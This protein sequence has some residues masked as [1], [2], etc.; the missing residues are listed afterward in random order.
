MKLNKKIIIVFVL[1]FI[2]LNVF[3]IKNFIYSA[4]AKI[5]ESKWEY[6]KVEEIS[7][8]QNSFI[9]KYNLGVSLYKEKEYNKAL[10]VFLSIFDT[11]KENF[12]LDYNIWNSYYKVWVLEKNSKKKIE[13][14]IKAISYYEKA[15]DIR[16][17][18]KAKNNI[19]FILKKIKQE[20]KKQEQKNNQE[21]KKDNKQINNSKN[22]NK[23]GQKDNS[24]KSTNSWTWTNNNSNKDKKSEN[25]SS[26]SK[27]NKSNKQGSNNKNQEN[28]NK[29]N[30]DNKW[31]KSSNNKQEW[32]KNNSQQKWWESNSKENIQ[33]NK[34]NNAERNK[35]WIN[36]NKLVNQEK[37][38]NHR[39]ESN[40]TW[41]SQHDKQLLKAYQNRVA[42]SSQNLWD[43]YWKVYKQQ[44]NPFDWFDNFFGWNDLFNN[45]EFWNNSNKKD[46]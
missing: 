14:W 42:Q 15:L 46:W 41:L 36:W 23:I 34:V 22:K 10:A 9:W 26:N 24:N 8:K 17:D 43:Y 7:K 20:R 38:E 44:S 19:E 4:Y 30:S 6:K 31:N 28:N 32:E 13:D 5:L 25:K 1:W 2:L 16:Y 11:K 27:E 3:S 12:N 29:W 35:K 45:D 33:W 18:D 37:D 39:W 40:K 21:N